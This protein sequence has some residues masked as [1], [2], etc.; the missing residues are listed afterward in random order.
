MR[1]VAALPQFAAAIGDYDKLRTEL[2]GLDG[3]YDLLAPLAGS[4]DIWRTAYQHPMESP[5]AIVE[6]VKSTGLRP[7]VDPLSPELRDAY[8]AEYQR[9]INQAYPERPDG[10]RLLAF[11]RLFIV[12]TRKS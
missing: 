12:A 7:F 10:K 5:A 4:I 8:L 2:L 9:R 11:P 3:Y 1:E 6:W